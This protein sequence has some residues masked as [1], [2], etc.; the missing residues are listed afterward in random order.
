MPASGLTM[1]DGS[2]LT[3]TPHQ[4]RHTFATKLV[5]AGMSPQALMALLGHVTPAVTLPYAALASPTIRA[6][7]DVRLLHADAE[8]RGSE[9]ETHRHT[10]TIE[11]L[12]GHLAGL[13]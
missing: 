11:R 10:A 8:Q 7:A 6:A 1:P 12:E 5:N 2:P 4:L 9:H 13:A 3:V